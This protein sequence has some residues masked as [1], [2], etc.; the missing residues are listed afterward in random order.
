MVSPVNGTNC[1]PAQS[2]CVTRKVAAV[3]VRRDVRGGSGGSAPLFVN[4]VI[5][6]KQKRVGREHGARL[7][8]LRGKLEV[9]RY[10]VELALDQGHGADHRVEERLELLAQ[11]LILAPRPP[12]VIE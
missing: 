6:T 9:R 5:R 10:L 7:R 4:L 12:A 11:P 3:K 8:L 1:T 2:P